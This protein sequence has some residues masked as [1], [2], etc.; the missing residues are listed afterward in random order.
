MPSSPTSHVNVVFEKAKLFFGFDCG[1]WEC[2]D[3]VQYGGLSA[4]LATNKGSE[5]LD[6]PIA[7]DKHVARHA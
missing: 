6:N 5:D 2:A 3:C 1:Q 7:T 4:T